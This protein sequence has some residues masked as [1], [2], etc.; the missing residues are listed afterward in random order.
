MELFES[1]EELAKILYKVSNFMALPFEKDFRPEIYTQFAVENGVIPVVLVTI[2]LAFCYFGSIV[3]K[4]NEPFGLHLP[5]AAWN[6]M[7][8]TFSFIGMFRT[9][10]FLMATIL[11]KPYVDTICTFPTT[12]SGMQ[13]D[14]NL[15]LRKNTTFIVVYLAS[16]K[17]CRSLTC[18][19]FHTFVVYYSFYYFFYYVTW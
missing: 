11:S 1:P 9:V 19:F 6:F 3:M 14:M 10:P 12:E 15:L 5:L 13:W 4:K 2:Y 18:F 17:L 8:S 7:L 16:H